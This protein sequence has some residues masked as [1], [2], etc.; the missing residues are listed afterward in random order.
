LTGRALRDLR[1]LH[2][3]LTQRELAT[4]LGMARNTITRYERGF[5]PT[6]P[7]Y[8]ELAVRGLAAEQREQISKGTRRG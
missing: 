5:L 1:R 6:I 8:V 3:G 7:K 4:K 2:L